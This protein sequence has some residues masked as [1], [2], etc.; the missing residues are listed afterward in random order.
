MNLD[1]SQL[2]YNSV[3]DADDNSLR[4]EKLILVWKNEVFAPIILPYAATVIKDC[5]QYTDTVE[6]ET[7]A[8]GNPFKADAEKLQAQ[9]ISF[10]INDYRKRRMAKMVEQPF[11]Y[12]S[13]DLARNIA[14]EEAT[15]VNGY[16]ALLYENLGANLFSKVESK[17]PGKRTTPIAVLLG[18]G[19]KK[20]FEQLQESLRSSYVV[21]KALVD[22]SVA[23]DGGATAVRQG[24]QYMLRFKDVESL[25]ADFSLHLVG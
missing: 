10:I 2:S 25:I 19:I 24:E 3:A 4:Y 22:C 8:R 12:Q 9:R 20:N 11:L 23:S 1:L 17:V 14:P 18:E 15:F 13:T 6:S 21:C 5:L 16:V 7:A